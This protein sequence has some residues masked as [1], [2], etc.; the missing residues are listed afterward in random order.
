MKKYIL[1]ILLFLMFIPFYVNAETCDIDKITIDNITIE[2]KSNNVE[3]IEETTA[4]GRNIN[5]NLSMSEVGDNI[6]YKFVVKNNSNEDYE[7]DNTSLNIN[8]DYIN[9]SFETEDNLNIV[10]ANSSKN[11]TL[12]VEYKTEVPEDKFESGSY[13]D[14]KTMTIQLSNGKTINVPNT[15]KNPNTGVQTY[16]LIIIILLIASISIYVLLKKKSYVKFMI[17]I[18]SC[19]IIIPI[20]VYALCKTEINIASNIEFRKSNYNPCI[21][22]GDLVQGAEYTN[23]QYTYRYMQEY[24]EWNPSIDAIDWTNIS[25]EGWGV[26][27]T[28]LESSEPVTT[29]LCTTINGKPIV[30]LRKTFAESNTT[31]IDLSSF[32]TSMVVN[33]QKT[34]AHTKN[35]EQLNLSKFNTSKVKNMSGMFEGCDGQDNDYL[36]NGIKEL[37][38]SSFDTSSVEN[39]NNMFAGSIHLT[40]INLS[41]FNTDNVKNMI[42]MFFR[43]ES[44]KELDLSNFNTSKVESISAMFAQCYSLELLDISNFDTTNIISMNATFA[45]IGDVGG[46]AV[47]QESDID[48]YNN[49]IYNDYSSH[50]YI[51]FYVK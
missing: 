28:N 47:K 3:E 33:M 15:I 38:L 34:F 21:Y 13:R 5:L 7:I 11:V 45:G 10:K 16:I 48:K 17:L 30:S 18:I 4:N 37:D 42:S 36:C 22:E 44:L 25:E 31:S 9:Y 46:V 1:P 19:S 50:G 41:S 27:L 20:S 35:L 6:E 49:S 23:G 26:H 2:N 43:N 8:S 39:M 29:S 24:G 40:K 12:R 32:D 51:Y 14:N